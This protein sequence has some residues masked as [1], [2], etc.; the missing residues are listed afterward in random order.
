MNYSTANQ[1]V[2]PNSLR[3]GW[4]E[5]LNRYKWDWFAT[6][7]PRDLPKSYTMLNRFKKWIQAIQQE[8][9]RLVGYYMV[10]EWFKSR[11]TYHLHALMGNLQG[12]SRCRWWHWWWWR[13]GRNT[14]E[15]YI[16]SAGASS[17]LTKYVS[18]E[19]NDCGSVHIKNLSVVNKV[20]NVVN[21]GDE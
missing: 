1:K 6:L 5:T 14:I 16:L 15:P 3:G 12:V 19:V 9:E 13:Y 7:T 11:K 20:N 2:N 8:E 21:K 18:K 17:Y 10:T 4:I